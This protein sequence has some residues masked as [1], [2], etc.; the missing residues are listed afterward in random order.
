MGNQW[1]GLPVFTH[2]TLFAV[3]HVPT[4]CHPRTPGSLC[5][6]QPGTHTE[7]KVAAHKL[8]VDAGF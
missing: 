4:C 3:S 1:T 7:V 5:P 8:I 2:T 6:C